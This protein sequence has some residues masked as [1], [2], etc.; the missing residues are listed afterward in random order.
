MRADWQTTA[1]QDTP[2]WVSRAVTYPTAQTIFDAIG[3]QMCCLIGCQLVLFV[4]LAPSSPRFALRIALLLDLVLVPQA[5]RLP[6]P[7][8]VHTI[9]L[10]PLQMDFPRTSLFP[11]PR[12]LLA[13]S[14]SI[15]LRGRGH[16]NN[17][18]TDSLL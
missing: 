3:G 6:Q 15:A 14:H 16:T 12:S 11:V 9:M 18:D 17:I 2:L 1:F 4:V 7:S 13:K 5:L 8:A 10:A